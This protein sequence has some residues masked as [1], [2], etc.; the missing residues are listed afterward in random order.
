M[1]FLIPEWLYFSHSSPWYHKLMW[2]YVTI[3]ITLIFLTS[4]FS[5]AV[6]LCLAS[7]HVTYFSFHALP[8]A[9]CVHALSSL[10]LHIQCCL[11]SWWQ[12]FKSYIKRR[13]ELDLLLSMMK[14]QTGVFVKRMIDDCCGMH[15]FF[16][17]YMLLNVLIRLT[18]ETHHSHYSKVDKNQSPDPEMKAQTQFHQ[19]LF[20][21]FLVYKLLKKT[22]S[23]NSLACPSPLSRWAPGIR[24]PPSFSSLW[25]SN[26]YWQTPW[27]LVHH[28]T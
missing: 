11:L 10:R 6:C 20:C 12:R 24:L 1:L 14:R 7:W 27:W 8:F 17:F 16:F 22:W 3:S 2:R 13:K 4:P 28:R 15:S 26:Y 25:G 23:P 5:S 9:T 21:N 18:R 19:K